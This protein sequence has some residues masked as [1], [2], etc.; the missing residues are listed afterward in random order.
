MDDLILFSTDN[1]DV[2]LMNENF[3][4][5]CQVEGERVEFFFH[6]SQTSKI[7]ENCQDFINLN[8]SFPSF[9]LLFFIYID[10]HFLRN[11]Y[12]NDFRFDSKEFVYLKK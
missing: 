12:L 10:T 6:N 9:C 11:F 8:Q 1:Q 3:E 5:F 7:S 4:T 2:K